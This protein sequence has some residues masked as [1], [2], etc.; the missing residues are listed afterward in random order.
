LKMADKIIRI[1]WGHPKYG[2]DDGYWK[3]P[4]VT[5]LEDGEEVEYDA[6]DLK[7]LFLREVDGNHNNST[8]RQFAKWLENEGYVKIDFPDGGYH[9]NRKGHYREGSAIV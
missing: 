6:D 1:T 7:N 5:R 4:I 9:F 3:G 2:V 8:A